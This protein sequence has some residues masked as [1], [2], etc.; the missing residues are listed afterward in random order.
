MASFLRAAGWCA[1]SARARSTSFSSSWSYSIRG[2]ARLAQPEPGDLILELPLLLERRAQ[3]RDSRR[4][5]SR[6]TA[7]RGPTRGT[8]CPPARRRRPR[9]SH[10]RS[11]CSPHARTPAGPSCARVLERFLHRDAAVAIAVG[12]VAGERFDE[13][14]REAR[15]V[16][17]AAGPRRRDDGPARAGQSLERTRRSS[18]RC[19]RRRCAPI[20]SCRAAPA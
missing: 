4:W 18:S 7:R 17:L 9:A 8:A 15:L 19:S 20:E 10:A 16:A 2:H 1:S 5:R 14:R 3:R 11:G 6:P 12:S 13:E